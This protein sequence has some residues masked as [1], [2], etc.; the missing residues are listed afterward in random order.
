MNPLAVKLLD[1]RLYITRMIRG[2][3][4]DCSQELVCQHLVLKDRLLTGDEG[5]AKTT[6]AY[7][8]KKTSLQPAKENQGGGGA[9]GR[10]REKS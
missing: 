4:L 3:F 6:P 9:A 2:L 7:N 1:N 10:Q 5:R 8:D